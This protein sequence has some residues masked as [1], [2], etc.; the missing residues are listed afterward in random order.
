MRVVID[1]KRWLRGEGTSNSFLLRASDGK[2]CCLGHVCKAYGKTD[3]ELLQVCEPESTHRCTG[4]RAGRGVA[5]A[6]QPGTGTPLLFIDEHS[7][8]GYSPQPVREA[9]MAN[10]K[11]DMPEAERERL[12]TAY[13][14]D[15]GIEIAFED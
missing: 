15:V 7:G 5:L 3:D 4:G 2:M 11:V 8:R 14:A 12:I 6:K 13:L 1:R 10:D 9:M